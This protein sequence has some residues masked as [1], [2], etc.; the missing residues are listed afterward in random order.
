MGNSIQSTAA[1]DPSL[2]ATFEQTAPD[3]PPTPSPSALDAKSVA[4]RV[5]RYAILRKLGE[6]GMGVVYA[7][8][9]EELD[10]KVAVKLLR[11]VGPL[12][13][14]RRTRILREAQAMARISHPNVVN[15][16]EVGEADGQVF[17]TMEFIEGTTLSDWQNSQRSWDELLRMYIAAGHG[18]LAA[19][20]V[21]LI[22]RDFKPDNVLVGNDQ[23]PRVADFGLARSEAVEEPQPPTKIDADADADALARSNQV[24]QSPLTLAGTIMGTPAY[25]S[26][27]QHRGEPADNRSDQFSFCAA[28]Y[29][30]LYKT[31]P[32]AGDSLATLSFNIRAGRLRPVP[33]GSPVPGQIYRA[34]QRG[35][36]VD[37]T[38]RFP[39]MEELLLALDIDPQRDPAGAPLARRLFSLGLA[40]SA[41]VM[42]AISH[43]LFLRGMLTN[44]AQIISSLVMLLC[45][46]L[47]AWFLRRSLMR[48]AF[49]RGLTHLALVLLAEFVG[50]RLL[51]EIMNL[52][53]EQV[54]F[55][56]LLLL[57]G[58]YAIAAAFYL[59]R[60]W[61]LAALCALGTMTRAL[62]PGYTTFV[63]STLPAFT[64]I[65]IAI[66]WNHAASERARC[67]GE[68]LLGA[69]SAHFTTTQR[70]PRQGASTR[71]APQEEA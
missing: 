34:L 52:S 38:A 60:A 56:E 10:R 22:H 36:A 46:L 23:R 45:G 55:I 58:I 9:D 12:S 59:P 42:T 16:Y 19:H 39:S 51:A 40:G 50:V 64:A 30:A 18:L 44:H 47:V 63:I 69:V 32:F 57:A 67:E 15:I 24:L 7:G 71:Q 4:R 28:L 6:G 13:V 54:G 11:E 20:K 26:P 61:L 25:M 53:L 31:L 41:V 17:I 5:G 3:A 27:E 68:K 66:M 70:T 37:P 65:A 8:Y 62:A 33:H 35:L 21:G 29:E 14:E 1:A 49:H 43:T 2:A 48:N